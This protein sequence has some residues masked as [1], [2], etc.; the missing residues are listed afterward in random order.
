MSLIPNAA[1]RVANY[2]TMFVVIDVLVVWEIDVPLCLLCF[3]F[4]KI[5]VNYVCGLMLCTVCFV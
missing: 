3:T 2:C 1:S 4:V 5:H